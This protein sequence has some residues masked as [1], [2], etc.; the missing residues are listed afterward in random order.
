MPGPA[1]RPG[2]TGTSS[3]PGR[4]GGEP[5]D[6]GRFDV[7]ASAIVGRPL[8]V[9][10]GDGPTVTDGI[11][12]E[13]DRRFAARARDAVIVQA[14]LLA[15][16][17]LDPDA[18]RPLR[19]RAAA[20][21]RHLATEVPRCV[22]RVAT[23]LPAARRIDLGGDRSWW[24]EIRPRRLDAAARAAPAP[25][26]PQ[27]DVL[28]DAADARDDDA[29]S[30]D[31]PERRPPFGRRA[32]V[33]SGRR[34]SRRGGSRTTETAADL[35][36]GAVRARVT[37]EVPGVRI[38]TTAGSP[39]LVDDVGGRGRTVA[40]YPE[41]DETARRYHEDWCRVH[42]VP[43]DR[44][45][46]GT[47][48][49]TPHAPLVRRR[50]AYLHLEHARVRRQ[51]DGED[52]NLDAV[53]DQELG[54]RSG[55]RPDDLVYDTRRRRGRDLGVLVLV[56]ASASTGKR[57][58]GDESVARRQRDAAAVL[59]STFDSLGDRV[60]CHAFR[61]HGRESVE[62]TAIKRFDE[63]HAAHVLGDLDRIRPEGFTR[64]G[65]AIRHATEL[66]AGSAGTRHQ[67]L[68]VLSDA[69]P[70]D[71]GYEGAYAAADS[72]RALDEARRARR[73]LPVPQ[74]RRRRG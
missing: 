70:F 10:W 52:L 21:R 32:G 9:G 26:A 55:D 67:L 44:S 40:T 57:H 33:P 2:E 8:T 60:S 20:L 34:R 25:A 64:L 53:I 23:D 51:L 17:A 65:A 54:R 62:F 15:G 31:G 14:A 6:A 58:G 68:V 22:A 66:L 11:T 35:G 7:L 18:L 72:R 63:R 28:G 45:G 61:S 41:W 74:H 12:I 69:F 13:L 27:I 47:E 50:I 29:A 38:V 30:G 16:G 24:G 37:R 56:D 71:R 48:R 36:A 19:G 1:S 43:L 59:V 39:A 3:R 46:P 49:E 5:F 4:T 73:R 42:E